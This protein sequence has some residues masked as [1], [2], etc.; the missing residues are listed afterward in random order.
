MPTLWRLLLCRPHTQHPLLVLDLVSWLEHSY[1]TL[2]SPDITGARSDLFVTCASDGNV[3]VWDLSDYGV[4]TNIMVPCPVCCVYFTVEDEIICG[5]ADGGLQCYSA[6]DGSLLWQ[7][8][9][10]HSKAVT[11]IASTPECYLSTGEDGALRLWL[12]SN[13]RMLGQFAEHAGPIT[14]MLC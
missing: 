4:L 2:S 13:R 1:R 12:K 6:T 11:H 3:R 10:A 14:G 5:C 9:N 8:P 7:I